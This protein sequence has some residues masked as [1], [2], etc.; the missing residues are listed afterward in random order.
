MA[1][2]ARHARWP[3][4]KK[5]ASSEFVT[6]APAVDWRLAAVLVAFVAIAAVVSRVA[7]FDV[8]LADASASVRAV[9]QLAAVSIVLTAVLASLPLAVAFVVLMFVVATGTASFRIG[10]PIRQSPWIAL[11]LFMGAGPVVGLCLASGV[12]PLRGA[13]LIPV[14]GIILG[15]AMMSAVLA[16]RRAFQEL[17]TQKEIWEGALALGARPRDAAHL[18]INPTA[19]EALLP[20]LDQTRTVGLVALP[21]TFV[22]VILGGG[23]AVEAGAA[24]VL[25]LVGLLPAQALA[26][27]AIHRLVAVGRLEQKTH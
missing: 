19:R 7:E 23:S 3:R 13:G 12:V 27:A 1:R 6:A 8:A 4:R 5:T 21:G 2:A 17:A 10:V 24:Q 26:T 16:G 22:G 9:L 11:A 15:G 18:V 25:V 20:A 14:A